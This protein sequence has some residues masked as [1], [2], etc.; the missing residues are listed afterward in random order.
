[1]EQKEHGLRKRRNVEELDGEICVIGA[2]T[3]LQSLEQKQ[4]SGIKLLLGQDQL[5]GVRN[6]CLSILRLSEIGATLFLLSTDQPPL[7]STF[8]ASM[9]RVALKK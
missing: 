4:E 7:I 3:L 9:R 6:F 5:K 8:T 1:M 2:Q